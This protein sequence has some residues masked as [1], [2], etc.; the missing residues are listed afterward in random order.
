MGRTKPGTM[1]WIQVGFIFNDFINDE[2]RSGGEHCSA[3]RTHQ[4]ARSLGLRPAVHRRHHEDAEARAGQSM[5]SRSMG[6]IR[7]GI[8]LWSQVSSAFDVI[9]D[10]FASFQIIPEIIGYD[11]ADGQIFTLGSFLLF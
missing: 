2:H 11:N 8:M 9:N 7:P 1:L 4:G 5:A 10:R 3:G 6:R